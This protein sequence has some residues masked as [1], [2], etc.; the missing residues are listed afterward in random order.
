MKVMA[1]DKFKITSPCLERGQKEIDWG[2]GFICHEEDGGNLLIP[3]QNKGN[4]L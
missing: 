3:F 1:S 4:R 2:I